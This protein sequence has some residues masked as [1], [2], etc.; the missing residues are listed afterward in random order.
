MQAS[1]QSVPASQAQQMP[2]GHSV[3]DLMPTQKWVAEVAQGVA[4]GCVQGLGGRGQAR[5]GGLGSVMIN[6]DGEP[7]VAGEA[8]VG[9][10]PAQGELG[11][12]AV[13]RLTIGTSQLAA[14][15]NEKGRVRHPHTVAPHYAAQLIL[16]CGRE[17]EARVEREE[18]A[19]GV[20]VRLT[21][22]PLKRARKEARL[23]GEASM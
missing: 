23:A 7:A 18:A 4:Q 15:V 5:A 14:V 20:G 16:E 3:A 9:L 17:E 21:G 1:Q 10:I 13:E 19:K 2:F 22:L 12:Y 6:T 8:A 11:E